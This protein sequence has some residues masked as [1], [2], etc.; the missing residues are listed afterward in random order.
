MSKAPSFSEKQYLPNI[1]RL[2][3]WTAPLYLSVIT[4]FTEDNTLLW[5]VTFGTI[6][7]A[8]GISFLSL[9]TETSDQ[10][11]HLRTGPI[12]KTIPY[13]AIQDA[14]IRQYSPIFDYGGWGIRYSKK[15]GLAWNARGNM[16]IQL[17]LKN[18]KFLI[19]TQKPQELLNVIRMH[20]KNEF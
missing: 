4:P 1:F 11:I 6:L 20:L 19:G 5:F 18:H 9:K 12:S 17:D 10:G 7:L 16:G 2:L 15:N 3:A 14:E 13:S 8:I